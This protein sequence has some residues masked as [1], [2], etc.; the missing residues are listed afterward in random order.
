RTPIAGSPFGVH[1]CHDPHSIR[2]VEI[3]HRI[4]ESTG[5]GASGGRTELEETV[6]LL[7]H[8]ADKPLDFVQKT[9]AQF[10]RDASVEFCR[11]RIFPSGFGMKRVGLHCPTI[12]RMRAETSSP[13][14]P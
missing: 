6:G 8:L 5:Q 13:E 9:P 12:L 1:N 14:T 4:R 10:G 11:L 2:L 7:S 3:N